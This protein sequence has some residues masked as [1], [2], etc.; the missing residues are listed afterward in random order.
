MTNQRN[1]LD[2]VWTAII[3]KSKKGKLHTL[4]WYK[5]H[6][7]T[8]ELLK[9]TVLHGVVLDI[10]CGLGCRA[11]LASKKCTVIGIDT[12]RV[13]IEYAIK[14]FGSNFCVGDALMMPFG[15]QT[16]DNAFLLA[17]I[18]HIKD[19]KSLISEISR[20]LRPRGKLFISVTDRDYHG[21]PSHIHIFT[22]DSL[23]A[24]FKSFTILQSYVKGRIIFAI[25]Q[26]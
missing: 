6:L 18:E 8:K 4:S 20:I 15:D 23:L 12:S 26:F 11:F 19:L 24:I 7:I 3:Q 13:A 2:A 17:T 14:H 10:G 21:D 5:K 1:N 22:K 9:S 25:I 16:F